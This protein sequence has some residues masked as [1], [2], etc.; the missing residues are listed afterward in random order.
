MNLLAKAIG[1]L[2][3]E[4]GSLSQVVGEVLAGAK[5]QVV[6]TGLIPFLECLS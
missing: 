1:S 6:S 5:D 3:Q 4:T 2:E